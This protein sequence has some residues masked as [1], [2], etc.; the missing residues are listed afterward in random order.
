MNTS[1]DFSCGSS[2]VGAACLRE[3]SQMQREANMKLGKGERERERA[4]GSRDGRN[5]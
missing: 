2:L 5:R 4:T 3:C 1:L